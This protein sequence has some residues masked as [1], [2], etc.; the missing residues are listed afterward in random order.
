MDSTLGI[1]WGAYETQ[2]ASL[3]S[4]HNG[5]FGLG[6]CRVVGPRRWLGRLAIRRDGRP[7]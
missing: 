2:S 1:D 7:Q 5:R 4:P 6:S 3:R